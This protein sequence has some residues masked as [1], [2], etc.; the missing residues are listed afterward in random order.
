MGIGDWGLWIMDWGLG[1]RPN[2]KCKII[3]SQIPT[4]KE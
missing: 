2:D 1:M 4:L 3:K